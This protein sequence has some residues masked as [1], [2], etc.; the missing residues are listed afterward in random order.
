MYYYHLKIGLHIGNTNKCMCLG[1]KQPIQHIFS[2]FLDFIITLL[3]NNSNDH[4]L[5]QQS[6][7]RTDN[8]ITFVINFLAPICNISSIST[9]VTNWSFKSAFSIFHYIPMVLVSC[10]IAKYARKMTR[11]F[12]FYV[13]LTVSF[14]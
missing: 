5:D 9:V 6:Y 4:K 3:H 1:D 12:F 10:I 8:T 13:F 7:A 14:L 11:Y 2:T